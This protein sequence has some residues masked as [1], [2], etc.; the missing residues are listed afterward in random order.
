M[1]SGPSPWTTASRWGS[2]R[3]ARSWSVSICGAIAPTIA[4]APEGTGMPPW[5][6]DNAHVRGQAPYVG[7]RLGGVLTDE[8]RAACA[9]VAA[10][11]RRVEVVED[12]IEAY[13][14]GLPGESP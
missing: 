8:I 10:R 2:L 4:P 7:F 5:P 6:F 1:S 13:A 9:W 12:A 11:A 14:A 3:P